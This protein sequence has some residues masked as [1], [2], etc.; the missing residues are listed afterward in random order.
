MKN[1]RAVLGIALLCGPAA[2]GGIDVKVNKDVVIVRPVDAQGTVAIIGPPGCVMGMA[3]IQVT[4]QNKK[5]ELT[6][7]GVVAPDGSFIVQIP[8]L[9]KDSVK[10]TFV[11]A[12]RKK[13]DI[14]VKIPEGIL[15]IP[16]QPVQGEIRTEPV[17]VPGG[18]PEAP[19]APPAAPPSAED[20]PPATDNQIITGE[21][22][23]ESSG[24]IE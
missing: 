24:M 19:G 11:G 20:S 12:D 7:A 3:P 2:A 15:P 17:T 6:V 4:A 16:P 22:N 8:A 10:L 21:K 5:T 13:K 18:G 14:K 23:L 9:P 1:C